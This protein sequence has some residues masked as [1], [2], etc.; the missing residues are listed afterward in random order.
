MFLYK[1]ILALILTTSL[2]FH[3]SCNNRDK[4]PLGNTIDTVRINNWQKNFDTLYEKY[5]NTNNLAFAK[6]AV[7]FADS[8]TRFETW[9]LNDSNY[10]KAFIRL[11][12]RSAVC[13][14]ELNDFIRSRELFDKYLF[15]YAEYNSGSSDVLAYSQSTVANIYSR[16][17]DYKKALLLLERSLEFYARKKNKEDF[18]YCML[19]LSIALKELN[20]FDAATDSLGKILLLDSIGP[21]RKAKACIELADIYTRQENITDAVIQIQKAKKFLLAMSGNPEHSEVYSTLFNIEGDLLAARKNPSEA[22]AAYRQSIDSANISSQNLRNRETGKT[23]IAMGRAFVQLRSYDSAL[24]FYNQ[25][26]YTVVNIDTLD[27][28]SLPKQKELYAENTIAEALYARADCIIATGT[29]NI[30]ELENSVSCYKLAFETERKLLDAFSY[31]ESRQQM[32][33]ATR[34]QSE[35]AINTCYRLY[36]K[37]KN[38]RWANEAFLFAEHNKAFILTESVRRNTAASLYLQNDSLYEKL[39]SLKGQLSMIET[40]LGKQHASGKPDTL[41]TRSLSEARKKNEVALLE[42]EN[43]LRMQ[44]PAY[45]NWLAGNSSLTAE[46]LVSKTTASGNPFI[47]YFTAD[48]SVYAFSGE[49][50]KPLAFYKLPAGIKNKADA[51][52]LYFSNRNAILND[53]AGYAAIANSLYKL[54]LA[55]YVSTGNSTLLIIP[56]GFVSR[57]PFDALLTGPAASANI[58]AFP[59]LIKKQQTGYA[60]SCRTLIEQSNSA[61]TVNKN[62]IAAFA[63]VFTNRE[64]GLSPLSNSLGELDAVK[65]FYPEGKFFSAATATIKGFEDNCSNSAIIHL[66]THAGTGNNTAMPGIEFYDSTLYLNRI[67][68]LPLK[69]SLV[70]LSGCETGAGS[71]NKTEGLMSLARGF[72]YAGT[73]NVIGSLWPTDD[74]VSAD[75]FKHFY[76]NLNSH[77]FST[78]LHKA[79]LAVID[80]SSTASA[81]PYF[82]SGYIYIGSPEANSKSGSFGWVKYTLIASGLLAIAAFFALRRKRKN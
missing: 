78:A 43:S 9:L 35:K 49:K 57:I 70:V 26:L 29:E 7:S 42:A 41:L 5:W 82:W 37:T 14:H 16:Y 24:W 23:Y 45:A 34:K 79:K 69:A 19:N 75:M 59:F 74:R 39:Q 17:G 53:P 60:F 47:E 18:A 77:D 67:Y 2:L 6:E 61:N 11:V 13:L 51:L 52:L 21:K 33:E 15:L 55:P 50:N 20:R 72:S 8:L 3:Y 81:S 66:A 12:Y 27:R 25:A 62:N 48:S 76:S 44:N 80:N 31:D 64:R 63:P 68:T 58:S 1:T 56:D 65:Q 71:I 38:S 36:Q 10:R 4:A 22:L 54:V 30:P 28:F 46:E 73:K 40:E 32:L